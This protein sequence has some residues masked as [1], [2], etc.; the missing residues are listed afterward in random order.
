MTKSTEAAPDRAP[1]RPPDPVERFDFGRNWQRLVAEMNE[2]RIDAAVRSLR[3]LLGTDTL[4]GKSFLDIGSGSG[5]SSLAARRLGAR[6]HSFD[7]DE[8]S[9]DSTKRVRDRFRPADAEWTIEQGSI[10]DPEF[11][12][13]LGLFDVVYAWGV[14]HHTGFLWQAVDRATRFMTPDGQLALAI[15]NDQGWISGYWTQIKRLYHAAPRWRPVI[16]ALHAPYLLGLRWLI[17]WARGATGERRGM[18]LTVDMID[19]LGGWPF[20]VATPDAVIRFATERGLYLVRANTVGR[21]HGCNE[22]VFS[23]KPQ[24]TI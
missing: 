24:S 7:F 1:D 6:V 15:Y 9:V 18:S 12:A 19:W 13:R 23:K 2:P 11:G 3:E 14:L 8:L 5:L 17:R 4:A 22:F 20:A 16:F 10:L 21:R